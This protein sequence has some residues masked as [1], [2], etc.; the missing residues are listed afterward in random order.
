MNESRIKWRWGVNRWL[1]LSLIILSVI[2][3]GRISPATPEILLPAEHVSSHPLITL[4]VIGE[5][6]LTNTMVATLMVDF[7]LILAAL[8]VRRS[9]KS[10]KEVL[11]G[12]SGVIEAVVQYVYNLVET[13]AGKWAGAILPYFATILLLVLVANWMELI[14]GVDSIGLIEPAEEEGYSI[15]GIIPGL[16]TIFKEK[17]KIQS[18][19]YVLVPYVRAV[20]TDLNFTLGLAL[21]SVSMIQVMGVRSLGLGY[22]KKFFQFK[23]FFKMW[24]KPHIGPFDLIFP[25]VDIFVGI[26][27]LIAEIAKIISF[28]FRLFGNIFAGAVVLFVMGS[29]MPMIQSPFLILELLVGAIQAFVF[30]MLTMVFMSMVVQSHHDESKESHS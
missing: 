30:G 15:R 23:N 14:P 3:A 11:T 19:G 7:L 26:L 17:E 5:F 2:L 12:I 6:Y 16:T 8:A 22:F 10:G 9:I 1:I 29:L 25:F 4:P 21:V 13:T 18:G 20:A 28:T 24:L 27:E